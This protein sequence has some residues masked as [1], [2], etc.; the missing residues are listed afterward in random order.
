MKP[1]KTNLLPF[2]LGAMLTG[3][4]TAYAGSMGPAST[5][6]D[7]WT[8]GASA[9]GLQPALAQPL[10]Y[11]I[12]NTIAPPVTTNNVLNPK[13]SWGFDV[14]LRRNFNQAARDLSISY[15]RFQSSTTNTVATPLSS[16]FVYT[17][18]YQTAQ[19]TNN[20]NINAGD[21]LVGQ[22][23]SLNDK[24]S[25]HGV[26]GVAYANLR[27]TNSIAND[28]GLG[29]VA[30]V[31]SESYSNSPNTFHGA[32]PKV[33]VDGEY[34]ICDT[35]HVGLTGGVSAALLMGYQHTTST[36][37]GG[38]VNMNAIN[39]NITNINSNIGLRYHA[40]TSIPI[41]AE[42]GYKVYDYIND[43][44]L[45]GVYLSLAASFG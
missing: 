29:N 40:N 23:V 43:I 14:F 27:I 33:G 3:F 7:S 45:A 20:I 10:V 6:A 9:L 16:N 12:E 18:F 36:G 15:M 2:C 32:G 42:A 5:A 1:T 26:L 39:T 21:V 41:N 44:S 17:D 30:N 4:T 8:V 28:Q 34:M 24:L 13:F 22:N 25:L 19:G 38:T 31:S 35:Y 37:T 11:A